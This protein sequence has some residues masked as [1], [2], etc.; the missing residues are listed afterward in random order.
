MFR[1]A[2]RKLSIPA[3]RSARLT[4]SASQRNM[5][6]KDSGSI[7]FT[8]EELKNRLTS[9][10]YQVTQEKGT[11]R[12]FSGEYEKNKEKGTY[13]CI[14]CG[15]LLFQSK[16]KYDS[17]SGWPSFYKTARED[18]VETIE[19]KGH[20]MVRTEVVCDKCKAHLGHV[21]TDG[22]APTG[23]RYCMNSASLSFE[24]AGK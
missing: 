2:L 21:F 16:H 17:G 8:K 24:K 12:A 10:Q 7:G 11:E 23:E 14:V 18:A 22:P 15:N 5:S 20:G 3:L 9:L 4:V 6:A 13:K 19:D 1:Q